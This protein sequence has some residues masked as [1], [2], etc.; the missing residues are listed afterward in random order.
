MKWCSVRFRTLSNVLVPSKTFDGQKNIDKSLKIFAK[1]NELG[2]IYHPRALKSDG[3][4]G[5]IPYI[6]E[7]VRLSNLLFL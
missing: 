6:V 3:K 2:V 4:M 7:I 1:L 5:I